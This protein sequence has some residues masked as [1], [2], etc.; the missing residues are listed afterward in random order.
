MVAVLRI[1]RDANCGKTSARIGTR[2]AS[3]VSTSERVSAAPISRPSSPTSKDRSSGSRST[4]TTYAARSPRRLTST[5]QSVQPAMTVA[6]GRSSMRASASARS[7]GLA[8]PSTLVGDHVRGGRGHPLGERG[9]RLP[10]TG[11]AQAASRIGR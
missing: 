6:S 11:S 3:R 2:P 5:P 9:L 10:A 4:A 8:N 1:S 7:A